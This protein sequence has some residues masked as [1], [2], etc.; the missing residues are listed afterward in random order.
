MTE[1]F[2]MGQSQSVQASVF[3]LNLF[4]TGTIQSNIEILTNSNDFQSNIQDTNG[5]EE[6]STASS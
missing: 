3:F 6:V 5:S 1:Y 4:E 2:G